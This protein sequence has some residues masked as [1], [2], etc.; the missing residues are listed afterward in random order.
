M[1]VQQTC[2][3]Q[4]LLFIL[5]LV[6]ATLLAELVFFLAADPRLADQGEEGGRKQFDGHLDLSE[7]LLLVSFIVF[8]LFLPGFF[9]CCVVSPVIFA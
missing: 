2:S 6:A 1:S 8:F 4:I 7:T 5:V 9:R 3:L